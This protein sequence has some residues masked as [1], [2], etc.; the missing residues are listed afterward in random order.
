M[1]Y[2]G[3]PAAIV[4]SGV[5]LTGI[6]CSPS[7]MAAE[8]GAHA[9]V[10][11]LES[12]EIVVRNTGV[13]VWKPGQ[14]WH[15]SVLHE[16]GTGSGMDTLLFGSMRSF[17]V[18]A[19]GQVHVLDNQTQQ[20]HVFGT[21]GVWVR[22][23]GGSGSGPGEFEGAS[24]V[25]I[26]SNGEYFVMEM[27]RGRLNIL[28]PS[29]HYVDSMP[30]NSTGWDCWP[31]PGGRDFMGRYNAAVIRSDPEDSYLELARFDASLTP[32]DTVPMPESPVE[33]EYFTHTSED[34]SS[35]SATIPFQASFEWSFSPSGNLWTL[36]TGPYELAEVSP[37]GRVLRR[38]SIPIEPEAVTLAERQE[39]RVRLE[40]FTNQGGQIDLARIPD[41]KPA[42][43]FFFV[44]DDGAIWV[45]RTAPSEDDANRIFD[46][47][48]AE[49]RF[50]G[51]VRLS[52]ALQ[53]DPL[54]IVREGKLYGMRINDDGAEILV[55]A[56]IEESDHRIMD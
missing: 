37:H 46:L 43:E 15:V 34:G 17:D 31:Y 54:P 41:T 8:G 52:F 44:G 11:T 16:I 35:M 10:D 21:D 39:A 51:T 33:F 29:G 56:Q 49:G 5:L 40:W 36:L 28:S 20:I 14:E 19:Q 42:A 23:V 45:N 18:D 7:D 50:L 47:F 2:D 25:D 53:S 30:I 32:L 27:Q 24:R 38:I 1:Q 4:L 9:S 12:G 6:C 13:P 22:T 48:E 55:M 3:L 26:N